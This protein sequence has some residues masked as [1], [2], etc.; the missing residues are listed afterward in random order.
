VPVQ[1]VDAA[2]ARRDLGWRP[3]MGLSSGLAETVAWYRSWFEGTGA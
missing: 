2:R 1:R 3:Q